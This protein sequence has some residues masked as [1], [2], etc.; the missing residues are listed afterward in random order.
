MPLFR[1]SLTTSNGLKVC[2]ALLA[3]FVF[4]AGT[5]RSFKLMEYSLE[6]KIRRADVVA[7]G[8]AISDSREIDFRNTRDRAARF[9]LASFIKGHGHDEIELLL[10]GTFSDMVVQC[11]ELG[12]RYMLF[13]RRVDDEHY[14]SINGHFGVMKIEQ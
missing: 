10:A 5:A 1:Q 13:L 8:Y 6:E 12:G 14:Q 3:F 7:V 2:L 11:C 9:Y 4:A